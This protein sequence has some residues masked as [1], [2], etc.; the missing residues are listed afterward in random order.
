MFSMALL[1]AGTI[2][3]LSSTPFLIRK[4]RQ[5]RLRRSAPQYPH[6][7]IVKK[8]ISGQ[9]HLLICQT[10]IVEGDDSFFS[11]KGEVRALHVAVEKRQYYRF[12]VDSEVSVEQ[13]KVFI[14]SVD[15]RTLIQY[16]LHT[17]YR[18]DLG[19]FWNKEKIL[20]L[21]G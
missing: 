2:V 3:F 16:A 9:H 17:E 12:L 11:T 18:D 1:T 20:V 5:R 13:K 14:S 15:G 4:V 6:A 7:R 19:F 21:C 8:R 10:F